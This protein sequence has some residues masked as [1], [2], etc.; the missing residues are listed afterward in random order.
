M[1]RFE[2]LSEM[3]DNLDIEPYSLGNASKKNWFLRNGYAI[4]LSRVNDKCI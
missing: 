3:H 2:I 4:I 1:K